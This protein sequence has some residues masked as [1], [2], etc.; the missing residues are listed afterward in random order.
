MF[1]SS[2]LLLY[3]H[4]KSR[5]VGVGIIYECAVRIRSVITI[6]VFN[7]SMN[8]VKL[9]KERTKF[10]TMYRFYIHWI[11]LLNTV[12]VNQA[13]NCMTLIRT[14]CLEYLYQY[15][16]YLCKCLLYIIQSTLS[17]D[18]FSAI[19]HIL[20][21]YAKSEIYLSKHTIICFHERMSPRSIYDW[22]VAQ[23]GTWTGLKQLC[24]Q[25]RRPGH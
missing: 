2:K 11:L 9:L 15:A 7:L 16:C 20:Y 18:L 22:P 17:F 23:C 4:L 1:C 3:M 5:G 8:D 14:I 13:T 24:S 12:Q 25:L 19:Y 21:V 10:N 6:S